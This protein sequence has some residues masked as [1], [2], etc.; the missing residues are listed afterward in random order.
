MISFC[1]G[2]AAAVSFCLLATTAAHAAVVYD[3][4]GPDGATGSEAAL[5]LEA[6][7]FTLQGA[8]HLTGATVYL[9]ATSFTPVTGASLSYGLHADTGAPGGGVGGVLAAG[10]A[11]GLAYVDTGKFF[12]NFPIYAVTFDFQ[13]TFAAA[14]D[15][16]YWLSIH[17]TDAFVLA[18]IYF[19][20]TASNSTYIDQSNFLGNTGFEADPEDPTEHA[21]SLRGAAVPEPATWLLLMFGFG[22]TGAALRRGPTCTASRSSWAQR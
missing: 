21:F 13:N 3:N 11:T 17:V 10:A 12:V 16:T 8:T 22:L 15:T 7:D 18:D 2:L 4:G 1:R 5:F 14:G 19:A 6:A 9:F 20:S